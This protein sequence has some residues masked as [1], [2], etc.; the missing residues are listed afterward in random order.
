MIKGPLAPTADMESP[1][2]PP[3]TLSV[4][5]CLGG[6][7]AV[8]LGGG[9]SVLGLQ[10]GGRMSFLVGDPKSQLTISDHECCSLTISRSL[11]AG[12]LVGLHV[13]AAGAGWGQ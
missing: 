7:G 12:P 4:K 11:S 9:V 13:Q 10:E 2:P 8:F 6:P 3:E 5:P 1:P